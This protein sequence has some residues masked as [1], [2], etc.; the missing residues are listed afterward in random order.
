[1]ICLFP[2]LGAICLLA[3]GLAQAARPATVRVDY[4]HCGN[5]LSDP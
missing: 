2:H 5:A 1:M 3:A 4:T